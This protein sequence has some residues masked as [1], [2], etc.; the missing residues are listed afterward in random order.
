M[1][2][3][4]EELVMKNVMKFLKDKT[5]IIMAH[6]LNTI[7]DVEKI[8]VFKAG[9]IVGAGSFK[10]L[11]EHNQYFGQLWKAA[12][13]KHNAYSQMIFD[14]GFTLMCLKENLQYFFI[15]S[16]PS[17][18]RNEALFE[19]IDHISLFKILSDKDTFNTLL[20]LYKRENKPFTAK[21][22]NKSLNISLERAEEILEALETYKLITISEVELDDDIIKIYNFIPNPAFVALLTFSKEIIVRPSHFYWNHSSRELLYLR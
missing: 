22:L 19:G 20:L 9:E 21:L 11:L 5:V 12:I 18:G 3:I 17:E 8:Y 10:E 15:T 1:D 4:T 7:T 6:R 13:E 16:E 2:N 14:S